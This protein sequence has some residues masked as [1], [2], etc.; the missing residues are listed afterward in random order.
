MTKK[1]KSKKGEVS[2]NKVDLPYPQE[3]IEKYATEKSKEDKYKQYKVENA[4]G[5]WV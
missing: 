5:L 4:L 3:I 2:F 1:I